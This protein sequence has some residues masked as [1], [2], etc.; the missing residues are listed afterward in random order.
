MAAIGNFKT[1]EHLR[2]DDVHGFEQSADRE[3]LSATAQKAFCVL[4]QNWSLSNTE[5]A[6]LLGVSEGAWKLIQAREWEQE[7][8][9][10]QLI[11]VSY[12]IGIYK[13]LHTIF[14]D[15][16]ADR[17]PKLPNSNPVFQNR[18]P[19]AAMI[20]EGV[21]LMLETRRHVEAMQEGL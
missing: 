15:A 18:S 7:L 19:V 1:G 2:R 20:G 13:G 16:M 12:L 4:S 14:A 6:A 3:R 10:D 17:W 11:R 5:A 21:P 9:E 8:S